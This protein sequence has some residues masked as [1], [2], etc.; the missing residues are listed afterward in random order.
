MIC[1]IKRSIVFSSTK[2]FFDP[3]RKW[4]REISNL[5]LAVL[6]QSNWKVHVLIRFTFDKAVQCFDIPSGHAVPAIRSIHRTRIALITKRYLHYTC[7]R[8]RDPIALQIHA[9]LTDR[10]LLEMRSVNT[11]V[12]SQTIRYIN[13]ILIVKLQRV[14]HSNIL[15]TLWRIIAYL[16]EKRIKIHSRVS[17]LI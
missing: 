14:L 11:H 3:L 13:L 8:D 2:P 4:N 1:D 5:S 17:R 6:W 16:C 10:E 12:E 7:T 9:G 15:S